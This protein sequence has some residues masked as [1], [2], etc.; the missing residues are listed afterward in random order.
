MPEKS[1]RDMNRL[2]RQHYS[3]AART[4]RATVMGAILLGLAALVFGL[5]L[6]AY[7]LG[8][9]CVAE[10]FNLS[11]TTA[12]LME[13]TVDVGPLAEEV[14]T[15]YR[16]LPEERRQEM[17]TDAYRAAF[18][19]I[20][21][22]EDYRYVRE[23]L[24]AFRE[25][26]EVYDIYLAA[27]DRENCAIVY[28]ADPEEDEAYVCLPGDWESVPEREVNKF[29]SWDGSGRLYDIGST[30]K[31]G[32]LAT[33]GVPIKNAEGE[34]VAF[35]LADVSLTSIAG[36]MK[37]FL[38][39]YAITMFVLVNLVAVFMTR[40]MKKT[41][42]AP[43]NRIAEA[44][45]EYI[46]D[47]QEGKT[48]IDHFSNLKIAT[49]DEV[50][51]LALLMAD[52]E[53]GLS[54]Y[55][56]NLTKITAEK[57]RVGTELAL[58][59]RIQA[60]MLPNIFPAFPERPDFDV[61]ASM[62]PAK[63]VGG[64][65]YDFFLV[66]DEHLALVM[67]DVSGKGVPAALFMMISKILVQNYAMM[68]RSPKE[69]LEA[70]NAQICA[71]N[72]EEMFVTVWFGILDLTTG[73]LTAANAGHEYPVLKQ[74]DG[75]FELIKDK[76]GFVIG[77]MEG[78]RY[79]EYELKLDPGAKLF[80]YTDG[81]AEATDSADALFGT[82]RMLETLRA[83]QNEEPK[84]I[85]E[86][87]DRAVARFVGD[88]PQFDDLTMLCMHYIGKEPGNMKDTKEMTVEATVENITAVTDFVNAELE[89]LDCPLKA[90]MQ[91]D[92]AIDELFGNIAQY[93]YHPET[94]SATVRVEVEKEPL[95]VVISFIDNGKPYDPLAADDP[96][97]TLSAEERKAGGLGVFLVKKTM[98]AVSYEYKD[99]KN[100]LKIKKN[101]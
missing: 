84:E 90:Q 15:R 43:I 68:G 60:D 10:A 63:E 8:E 86:A 48:D 55:E 72:R 95:A 21:E 39:R 45:K 2:E 64:D 32:W 92:V 71:N 91:I 82:A 37:S 93:A 88:A 24:A 79:K 49:G 83:A 65:F 101:I 30:E 58:A 41:L 4:F 38:L 54:D 73:T 26:S 25:T 74:P 23:F 34:E 29:L 62:T 99:G 100:I 5:G 98:D 67:A 77:G 12:A 50:E 70:V 27:Y 97:V 94:G 85:L 80:L 13:Q 66:D 78:A 89:R 3:L 35:V 9:Q 7:A 6:Y 75:D 14:I 31:Y 36:R 40:H 51:N 19:D 96:D 44:A 33:S 59:T 17:G 57:E 61:Y 46:R 81:V 16:A 87:V 53:K 28:I 1:I 56:E 11:R 20:T 47:K 69:V 18:A 52:M 42:V 76:H 22:R